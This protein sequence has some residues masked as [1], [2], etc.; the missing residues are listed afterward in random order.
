MTKIFCYELRRLLLNKLFVGILVISLGYGWLTLTSVTILGTA[1]TAPFSPWS[2][3]DYLSRLLPMICLG[4]LFFLTFFTSRQ[5]RQVSVITRASPASRGKYAAVRCGAVLAGTAVLVLAVVGMCWGF[6]F[7]LFRWTDFASLLAPLALA[8]LPAAVFCLGLGW[9]LGRVHPALVYALAAAVFLLSWIPLP[10]ALG[11]S[12]GSFFTD[13]P[14]A[15]GVLD[16]AFSVPETV[17]WGRMAYFAVG[18]ASL[19]WG[20]KR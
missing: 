5:E 18:A 12:L 2:F 1:N 19:V 10:Q 14:Q 15:L 16:P 6:Y 7:W 17:L 11:F 3:G 13:C 8:L 4:E 20:M 9:A